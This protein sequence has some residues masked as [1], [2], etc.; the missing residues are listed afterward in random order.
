MN[1]EGREGREGEVERLWK[2]RNASHPEALTKEVLLASAMNS[3][4]DHWQCR[5][6]V[7][8]M[9]V[10]SR[11]FAVFLPVAAILFGVRWQSVA[12][13]PLWKGA[14]RRGGNKKSGHPERSGGGE[15]GGAQSKDL[16]LA[17][18]VE[19]RRRSEIGLQKYEVLRLRAL[20]PLCRQGAPLRMTGLFVRFALLR[21]RQRHALRVKPREAANHA[22]LRLVR[23]TNFNSTAPS[24]S[25][26]SFAL[27]ASFAV[28][29][30][31]RF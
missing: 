27:F 19:P 11:P 8:P 10:H 2:Y 4:W 7:S 23:Q 28:S 24:C 5:F 29:F 17:R 1:R 15:A 20:P 9:G 3:R 13:T 21:L 6:S 31:Q 14:K 22:G 25:S 12:A 30:P 16:I 18:W 26:L